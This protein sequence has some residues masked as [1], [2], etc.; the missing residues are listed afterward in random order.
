MKP[1][2][3]F[4]LGSALQTY[5][6]FLDLDTDKSGARSPPDMPR[7]G[8]RAAEMRAEAHGRVR[9]PPR[10]TAAL[11]GTLSP[12]ELA[13]FGDGGLTQLFV[14]RIFEARFN[15]LIFRPLLGA[16]PPGVLRG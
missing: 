16:C 4:T 11:A 14:D 13:R 9:T 1:R 5:R 6:Q 10:N 15:P 8:A 12:S 3:W 2:N 7:R